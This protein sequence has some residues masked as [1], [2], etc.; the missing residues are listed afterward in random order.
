MMAIEMPAAIRLHSTAVA[1]ISFFKN[2]TVGDRGYI[3]CNGMQDYR[4][5]ASL[6]SSI[7]ELE[8]FG[9]VPG[10]RVIVSAAFM[11]LPI[12]RSRTARV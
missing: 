11:R 7:R 2:A 12:A 3:P 1:S 6:K 8:S 4:T 5:G 10:N 9:K